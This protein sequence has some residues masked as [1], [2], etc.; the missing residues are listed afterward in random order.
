MQGRIRYDEA[1]KKLQSF[2][3]NDVKLT[4]VIDNVLYPNKSV[5]KGHC[6]LPGCNMAIRWEYLLENK[7]PDRGEGIWVGSTCVW[8]MLNLSA[9]DIKKFEKYENSVKEFHEM[10]Q[11]KNDNPDVWDR[12]MRLKEEG[13]EYY[14]PFWEEVAYCK[15]HI[16]DEEY[17][18]TFDIDKEI[19]AW[20]RRYNDQKFS[21]MTDK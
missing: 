9:D 11:W 12:L 4:K 5:A 1:L 16:E 17:I 21:E 2:Q 20:Q 3:N 6:Q 18:R 13:V 8:V 15:L 19:A 14:R 10:I 7:D